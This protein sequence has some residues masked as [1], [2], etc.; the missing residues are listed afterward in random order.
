M[1]ERGGN[2]VYSNR[3]KAW[4]KYFKEDYRACIGGNH[5]NFCYDKNAFGACHLYGYGLV[6]QYEY[7][8]DIAALNEAIALGAVLEGLYDPQ[9]TS[10]DCLPQNACTHYGYRQSGR[11]IIL[12]ARLHEATGDARWSALCERIVNL[13]L[14]SSDWSETYGMYF[15]GEWQTDSDLWSGAYAAG[16]RAY[17][18]AGIAILAEGLWHT[19]RTSRNASLK[20]QIESRLISMANFID[21][22]GLHPTVQYAGYIA[23]IDPKGDPHHVGLDDPNYTTSLVNLLVMGYKLT[24]KAAFL[25]RAKT[26]FNRGTKGV[27]GSNTQRLCADDEVHHFVD[28]IFASSTGYLYL[29]RNRAEL[30]YTYLIFEN[31]GNP[32]IESSRPSPPQNLRLVK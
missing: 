28:T 24:G 18:P 15:W 2:S 13:V 5:R 27:Y 7:N 32:T 30:L 22:Y 21:R 6:A 31:G 10:F 9:T 25:E 23:G 8:G 29:D 14:G 20:N 16:Y 1:V 19:W 12:A 26:F 3:A 11:H 17:W 4:L